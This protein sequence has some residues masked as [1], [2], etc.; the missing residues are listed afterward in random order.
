MNKNHT[1]LK[2]RINHINKLKLKRTIFG[3]FFLATIKHVCRREANTAECDDS[4]SDHVMWSQ[5]GSRFF[6]RVRCLPGGD[7]AAAIPG[8]RCSG[9]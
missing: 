1:Q 5:V 4:D 8:N 9:R 7:G 3:N 2:K 6:Y